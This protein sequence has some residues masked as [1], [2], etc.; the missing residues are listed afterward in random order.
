M[1]KQGCDCCSCFSA[2]FFRWKLQSTSLPSVSNSYLKTC[3]KDG[4]KHAL[5]F[6]LSGYTGLICILQAYAHC[7]IQRADPA[8]FPWHSE[9]EGRHK[10]SKREGICVAGVCNQC[11]FA[12]SIKVFLEHNRSGAGNKLQAAVC[13]ALWWSC[14]CSGFSTRLMDTP[15]CEQPP[16]TNSSG[17]KR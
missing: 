12:R 4:W 1:V 14:C 13:S 11:A 6:R 2:S 9:R 5:P 16:E 17:R 7:N 10:G 8:L 3:G 15:A